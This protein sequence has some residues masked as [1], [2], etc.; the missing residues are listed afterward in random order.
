MSFDSLRHFALGEPAPESDHAV[1][2]SL[3]T[4]ADV[5]GYEEKLPT[6]MSKIRSGYPRFVIHKYI[7]RLIKELLEEM[8]LSGKSGFV[9]RTESG[10]RELLDY[11]KSP[12]FAIKQAEDFFLVYGPKTEEY[13]SLA[14]HFLQH[15]GLSISSRQAEDLLIR[16]GILQEK[17]EETVTEHSDSLAKEALANAM[18]PEILPEDVILANSGANAFYALFQASKNLLAKRGRKIWV[19]LGWLYVDTIKVLEKFSGGDTEIIAIRKVEDLTMLQKLFEEKGKEIAAV[20]TETPT[21]PLIQTC[22][23]EEVRNLCRN[24]GAMLIVDPTMSSPLNVKVAGHADVIVNSLTKYAAN[25]GDVMLGCLAFPKGSPFREE[26]LESTRS[27]IA[28]PYQRDLDRLAFEMKDYVKMVERTNENTAKLAQFLASHPAV[29]KVHWAYSEPF[30]KNYEQLAGSERPGCMLAFETKGP[31]KGFYDKVRLLK[32]P[33]FGTKFTLLCPY[34]YLAHYEDLQH[35]EGLKE[36]AEAG[37][38]PELIRVSVG[39]EP[40]DQ[41]IEVFEEALNLS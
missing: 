36:L 38:E 2:I 19:Q 14:K 13:R 34:V 25:E 31:I 33:S 20:V 15:T 27:R 1:C 18:G 9:I 40:P 8:N 37:L 10:A 17:P 12:S 7:D 3:P 32:S 35:E 29:S 5:I 30:R 4:M 22:D 21:N 23:L 41:I 39:M 26:L 6:V 11:L 16:R 24:S 28:P